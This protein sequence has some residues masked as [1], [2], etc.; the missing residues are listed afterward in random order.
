MVVIKA[1][2]ESELT[3]RRSEAASLQDTLQQMKT[4]SDGLSQEKIDLNKTITQVHH[5]SLCLLG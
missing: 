2:L 1:E 3:R 5:F 4:T